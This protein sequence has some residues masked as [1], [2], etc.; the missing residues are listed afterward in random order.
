[1]LDIFI[2]KKT[3]H[4]I[5]FINAITIKCLMMPIPFLKPLHTLRRTISMS[6]SSVNYI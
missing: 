1:M 5:N 6:W 2:V 3:F 4:L